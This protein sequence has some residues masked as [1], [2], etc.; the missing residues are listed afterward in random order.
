[1]SG[2]ATIT[3]V[4]TTALP[5][6]GG[7]V[8]TSAAYRLPEW[9]GR[10]RDEDKK[11]FSA[12]RRAMELIKAAPSVNAGARAVA[13]EFGG[14]KGFT[15]KRLYGLYQAW[16]KHGEDDRLL[17]NLA[18]YPWLRDQLNGGEARRETKLSP[19]FIEYV[20]G[21]F[22]ANKRSMADAWR[23]LVRRWKATW[24]TDEKLPGVMPD[25]G[26]GSARDW[27]RL[28][29]VSVLRMER[30]PETLPDGWSRSNLQRLVMAWCAITP[31]E[32]ALARRGT[33][34][35]RAELPTIHNSR[36]G[37][38]FGEHL[39]ADDL[40]H[41][42]EV[43]V[44]GV[45][46]PNQRPLE[47]G[48]IDYASGVY[49]PFV[50]Q[51]TL[52]LEDG[53]RRMLGWDCLKYV[54][55]SWLELNG[56]PLDWPI[57]LHVENG[58][59]TV[60]PDEARI[61]H[62]MSGGII[63][64]CWTQMQGKYCLAWDEKRVGNFRGKACLEGVWSLHHNYEA[65][66][67]GYVGRNRENCPAGLQGQQREALALLK[68]A[69]TQPPEVV[70]RMRLPLLT[71]DEFVPLRMDIVAEINARHDHALEGF[72]RVTKW[73]P[74][75]VETASWRP[76]KE[77]ESLP[78]SARQFI[79][80]KTFV[81]SPL[82]RRERLRARGRW[83]ACPS[84]WLAIILAFRAEPMTV[85]KGTILIRRGRHRYWY[86]AESRAEMLS[87]GIEDG[88][89][90]LVTFNPHSMRCCH[91]LSER[92]EY[93][94][95]WQQRGHRRG[96]RE[97]LAKS[98]AHRIGMQ[99]EVEEKVER[100]LI[101]S[102]SAVDVELRREANAALGA[103]SGRMDLLSGRPAR[104]ADETISAPTPSE[105]NGAV[106]SQ[107]GVE[108]ETPEPL[109][110]E[111]TNGRSWPRSSILPSRSCGE[112]ISRVGSADA[113][114]D[115][116]LL[117]NDRSPSRMLSS[118][119]LPPDGSGTGQFAAAAI[120]AAEKRMRRALAATETAE[121]ARRQRQEKRIKA[122]SAALEDY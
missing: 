84:S 98:F 79:E 80:T 70:A 72:E 53:K 121:A 38:E 44:H 92:G 104:G 97:S 43:I 115:D 33:A 64:V 66:L 48:I 85:Q 62:A 30:C 96:D 61:W 58:T 35:M 26:A 12:R 22:L 105:D 78:S 67:P 74:Q 13:K 36:E 111:P 88:K 31:A 83:V 81:E 90:Y 9:F 120:C 34:A 15:A 110:G 24:V 94:A 113:S 118:G 37:V 32:I 93:L 107:G 52:P 76:M 122:L 101:A 59:A 11:L 23:E 3:S 16:Q 6:D 114:E 91:I 60:D 46:P 56:V 17:V 75:G 116:P 86:M 99:R 50:L 89:T 42:F 2:A 4:S 63:N 14:V 112:A 5:I 54:F 55:A 49:G 109:T 103:P 68:W 119:Q 8:S 65:A 73:R 28:R 29:D 25:G 18:K 57:H 51:P 82:E 40:H 1:M 108:L 20:G 41:D 27:W 7:T 45:T 39:F 95:T 19:A 71:W 47:V 100:L 102:G 106:E 69:A 87:A 77:L 21:L 10:L 117:T